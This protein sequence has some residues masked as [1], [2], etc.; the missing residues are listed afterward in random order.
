M[1]VGSRISRN[2]KK[3]GGNA[4]SGGHAGEAKRSHTNANTNR[5]RPFQK[6][7]KTVATRGGGKRDRTFAAS[8][9]TASGGHTIQ[10]AQSRSTKTRITYTAK[11]GGDDVHALL[12]FVHQRDERRK[13]LREICANRARAGSQEDKSSS[14]GCSSLSVTT[15]DFQGACQ[16]KFDAC[17]ESEDV[18]KTP[19]KPSYDPY[20]LQSYTT[21]L[22]KPGGAPSPFS[23]ANV[24]PRMFMQTALT[25]PLPLNS[26]T[27]LPSRFGLMMRGRRNHSNTDFL[28]RIMP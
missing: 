21:C 8:S 4:H 20:G 2:H 28:R 17:I 25:I 12:K 19:C 9:M 6:G 18:F 23:R 22:A 7:S 15:I 26:R 11:T 1:F 5:R 27:P 3:G 10:G 24:E 13:P 16:T 14:S